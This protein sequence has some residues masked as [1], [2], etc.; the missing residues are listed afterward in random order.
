MSNHRGGSR[1]NR[2][3]RA[4]GT[5]RRSSDVPQAHQVPTR[6]LTEGLKAS[7]FQTITLPPLPKGPDTDIKDLQYIGSYNWTDASPSSPT[8]LVPGCPPEWLDK[9]MPMSVPADRGW[10]FRDQNGF[11]LPEATLVPLIAAVD[12]HAEDEGRGDYCWS[13]IDIVTDRNGLRKLMRWIGWKNSGTV[14]YNNEKDFRIDLQLAGEKT[15]LFNRY[16]TQTQQYFSGYTFGFNFEKATTSRADGCE[17][18]TGHHR[19]VQ[20][21]FDGL[22][23]VVRFEVD[24]CLRTPVQAKSSNAHT[25]PRVEEK[26]VGASTQDIDQ[27]TTALAST[28]LSSTDPP[29]KSIQVV[30]GKTLHIQKVGSIVSQNNI[31]ELGTISHRRMVGGEIE[32]EE[33]FLQMRLSQTPHHYMGVHQHGRFVEL[34]KSAL[35]VSPQFTSAEKTCKQAVRQLRLLLDTI[36]KVVI[37]HG[38]KGRL[39]LVCQQGKLEVYNRVSDKDCIP[40]EFLSKFSQTT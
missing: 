26:A 37:Q 23:M 6:E 20:Y 16:E 8:I 4:R 14:A 32:W 11:R 34:Q 22:K 3:F 31:I 24:A 18:G 17:K 2:A 25:R 33:K 29:A 40:R 28:K 13:S 7:S 38:A 19:I 36:R 12:Q 10:F 1:P 9:P 30:D 15:I 5:A 21:D 39:T 35:S 27:L